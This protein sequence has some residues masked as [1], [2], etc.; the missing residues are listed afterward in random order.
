MSKDKPK[1]TPGPWEILLTNDFTIEGHNGDTVVRIGDERRLIPMNA[2]AALIAAAP[3]LYAA[4]EE[5]HL[6]AESILT[7]PQLDAARNGKTMRQRLSEAR[8]ALAKARG[9]S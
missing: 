9:E 1:F 8:A 2:D 3:E 6:L 7:E 4:L 5:M